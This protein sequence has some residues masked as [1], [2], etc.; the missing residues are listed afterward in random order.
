MKAEEEEEE[1]CWALK[2]FIYH[3]ISFLAFRQTPASVSGGKRESSEQ[4]DIILL[5]L[6]PFDVRRP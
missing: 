3:P 1:V 5:S 4:E 6:E 2:R